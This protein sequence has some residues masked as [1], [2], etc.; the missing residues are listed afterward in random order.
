MATVRVIQEKEIDI[1]IIVKYYEIWKTETWAGK[2]GG[3][4]GKSLTRP[5]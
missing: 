1:R 3:G 2:M 4:G 5:T